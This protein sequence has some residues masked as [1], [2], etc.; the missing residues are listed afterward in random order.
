VIEGMRK[1]GVSF[2]RRDQND[3]CGKGVHPGDE[4]IMPDN[5]LKISLS[6][7]IK[8]PI[9]TILTLLRD[10]THFVL[11]SPNFC[12]TQ[13][14]YDRFTKTVFRIKIR[15]AV[16]YYVVQQVFGAEDY[17]VRRL[18]RRYPD[19]IANY[20]AICANNKVP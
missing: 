3:R 15:D 20:R 10:Q 12:T 2:A 7:L 19:L 9:K 5:R 8:W 17:C 1:R 6:H 16:D 11:L 14:I 18:S 4:K 13:L